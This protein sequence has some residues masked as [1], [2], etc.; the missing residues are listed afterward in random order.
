MA[1]A[2][3]G[4]DVARQATVRIADRK[5]THH[6]QGLLLDLPAT[7][8]VVLTCHHVVA[9]LTPD[10][11]CVQLPLESGRLGKPLPA[12][13]VAERSRPEQDAVVLRLPQPP[14]QP[15]GPLPLLHELNADT[16][17]GGLPDP[18]IGLNLFETRGFQ[19]RLG[20]A[21]P[22]EVPVGPR[23]KW[24]NAPGR[25]YRVPSVFRLAD[26]TDA[27]QGISGSVMV[28]DGGVLG[29]AHFSRAGAED[30]KSEVYL[31]P[32]R[33]W[34]E[35]WDELAALI[36]PLIDPRLRHAAI[37]KRTRSLEP[38]TDIL[39]AKVGFHDAYIETAAIAAARSALSAHGGLVIIGRP[40]S[41]KTRLVWQLL[42]D[43]P[44]ALAVIPQRASPPDLFDVSI[45]TDRDV[46]LL[47]DDLHGPTLSHDPLAWHRRLE[48]AAR[49]PCALICTSRDGADWQRASEQPHIAALLRQLS[50]HA[51]VYT[52]RVGSQGAD[53]SQDE[54]RTLAARIGLKPQ[55]FAAR[56]DGTAGSLTLDLD[57]MSARYRALQK[58]DRLGLQLSTLLDAA[59]L[60]DRGGLPRLAEARLRSAAAVIA[61]QAIGTQAWKVL[62]DSTDDEGF[63]SF[64][65]AGAFQIYRPYLET[66]VD[67]EPT[68]QEVE[69]LVP[70]LQ[71][72]KD[73]EGMH[74]L[75]TRLALGYRSKIGAEVLNEAMANAPPPYGTM[76]F[77]AKA[78]LS[79]ADPSA[80]EAIRAAIAAG[81]Q[82][83]YLSLA[84]HLEKLPRRESEAE[85]AF[86]DAIEN[87]HDEESRELGIRSELAA[88][89]G[90]LPGREAD[91]EAAFRAALGARSDN[92]LLRG[93]AAREF[94]IFLARQPDR[95]DE[96]ETFFIEARD[97]LQSNVRAQ[98]HVNRSLADLLARRPGREQD[99]E[100]AY[101]AAIAD[102]ASVDF[103][104]RAQL[105][106][107]EL[108]AQQ[109]GREAEAEEF[110]RAAVNSRIA[111]A[112]TF[113]ALFLAKMPDRA[114]DAEAAARTAIE[115]ENHILGYFALGLALQWLPGRERE[116]ESALRQAIDRGMGRASYTLA[117]LLQSQPGREADAEQAY[118][119]SIQAGM[120]GVQLHLARLLV[121]LPGREADAERAYLQAMD[122]G[123][124]EAWIELPERLALQDGREQDAEA[125]YREAIRLGLV[126]ANLGLGRLL[127]GQPG[128]EAEARAALLAAEA[129]GI[130]GAAEALKDLASLGG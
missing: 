9:P 79:P 10:E 103:E 101:R 51:F 75:G 16:Y 62:R 23:G 89:L 64:N 108:L 32:L 99:A 102:E 118:R 8:T 37:V 49:R 65:E 30:F 93:I 84:H 105:G 39:I 69:S 52:S 3:R 42:Q 25:S 110:Y 12:E 22:L 48:D 6:G 86:R 34:A 43:R 82:G 67:Y 2:A 59:K 17:D 90:K 74:F 45:F 36:E 57:A 128:R 83:A 47:F 61:G 7:G 112:P 19:A 114:I 107:A 28:Y 53:L 130:A 54:G 116:A 44:D 117:A 124:A 70:V 4:L 73:Y 21:A 40:K 58:R 122:E 109:E 55:D 94:G 88:F 1:R 87:D 29:L 115:A 127:T 123:E 97:I 72:A 76:G 20:T 18:A 71:E 68:Q 85:Q 98:L 81:E 41:G 96:A 66:C 120:P 46:V 126:A 113:M 106:L 27:R 60:L 15:S 56:F 95:E 5:G 13:Y 125:I 11:L 129:E 38:H 14:Q 121:R 119:D 24:P 50:R 26:P 77:V 100:W 104:E 91:A 111:G 63:G 92:A 35:G 80:E 33:V 31:V 78:V